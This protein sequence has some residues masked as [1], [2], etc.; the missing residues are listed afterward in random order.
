MTTTTPDERLAELGIG[1]PDAPEPGGRYVQSRR[2]DRT[3][4]LAGTIS[5]TSD[6]EEWLGQVGD[7]RTL[8]EGR[9]AARA[10]ARNV[11]ARIRHVAG[12]LDAVD[13]FLHVDGYVN[14]VTGYGDSSTVVNA[15]SELF[16]EVYGDDGEHTRTAVSVAGLP[17]NATVEVQAE[18][19]LG[20]AVLTGQDRD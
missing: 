7:E 19:A 5:V 3:L 18:V 14:A 8:E 4:Y 6:G 10:C 17:K 20:E 11:L 13:R 12:S 16:V 1:L 9:R 2:L 15:A